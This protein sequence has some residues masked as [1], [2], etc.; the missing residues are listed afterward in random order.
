[1]GKL[2][3]V[4]VTR[5]REIFARIAKILIVNISDGNARHISGYSAGRF[6]SRRWRSDLNKGTTQPHAACSLAILENHRRWAGAGTGG[7][8]LSPAVSFELA[9]AP[10]WP[11][12]ALVPPSGV[13]VGAGASAM[14]KKN[15]TRC[16]SSPP[17]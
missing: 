17:D 2:W 10:L 6:P 1:M 14:R 9:R 5:V 7:A 13:V 16:C 3:F 8:P 11:R 15:S 12:S 4:V